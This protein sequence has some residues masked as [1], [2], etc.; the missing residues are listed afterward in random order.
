M[1]GRI[2]DIPF[3]PDPQECEIPDQIPA[4]PARLDVTIPA[5]SPKLPLARARKVAE[6]V[7]AALAPFC[8]RIEIAGSIRRQRPTCG[9]ID[10][11]VLP[12][13]LD[14]MLARI[15][16]SCMIKLSG[17][18]NTIAVMKDDTQLDIFC[19]TGPVQDLFGPQ[20]G[21]W[22]SLLLCRTGSKEHNIWL[23][24]Q[25]EAKRLK[26]NTYKGVME[27]GS[28]TGRVIASETEED[29]FAALGLAFV[30]PAD[31]EK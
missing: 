31:R 2:T 22:G 16:Q 15:G 29:I 3:L 23:C 18:L 19:A 4:R 30:R 6:H 9:D 1:T 10:L 12:R 28:L 25:A 7:A 20:P 21:N 13:D 27:G 8:H 5:E 24:Q 11:V 26:W 14:G 17:P